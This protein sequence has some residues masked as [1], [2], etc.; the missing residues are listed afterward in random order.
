MCERSTSAGE[1]P[2]RS[3]TCIAPRRAAAGASRLT[4]PAFVLAALL[5]APAMARASVILAA[6]LP[7]LPPP[8]ANGMSRGEPSSLTVAVANTGT[9]IV[10]GV[11]IRLPLANYGLF[12]GAS[13]PDGTWTVTL[14]SVT[15]GPDTFGLVQFRAACSG[16]GIPPSDSARFV[17]QF[18]APASSVDGD[19][20]SSPFQVTG[21][22][23]SGASV[24]DPAPA[25]QTVTFSSPIKALY[26]TGT[27]T[28]NS[29]TRAT[30]TWTVVNNNGNARVNNVTAIPVVSPGSGWSTTGCSTLA[31]LNSGTSGNITCV[32]N[33][34]VPGT[35][36]F[37]ASARDD[38]GTSTAAGATAGTFTYGTVP[39]VTWSKA[40]VVKGLAT[41]ALT[42]NVAAPSSTNVTR[43]DVYNDSAAGWT[44]PGGTAGGSAT[45]GLTYSAPPT[46]TAADVVFT[47]TLTAGLSTDLVVTYS[48]VPAPQS[49]TSYPF[50]VKVT[51]T[52]GPT[53]VSQAVWLVVPIPDVTGL[54]I[55]A[56]QSGQQ[57]SW[58]NT[59]GNGATH[60][61]VVV[62]R[63]P[64]GTAPAMPVPLRQYSVG[65]D[66]VVFITSGG[67]TVSTYL[68][69][70]P[71]SF[72]YRVCN[73]DAY[74]VYSA[75]SSGFW[76]G[77]GWIDAEIAPTGGWVHA[78]ASS[79]LLRNGFLPGNR[80]GVA[81]NG[82]AVN[83][84]DLATGARSFAPHALPAL[85]AGYTPATLLTGTVD[86]GRS[87]L[88]AADQS[89]N[90]TAI[91]LA[92]GGQYWQV[93]K[94]GASFTA[95]AA[96][97][98]RSSA[99]AAF[100]AAYSVDILLIGSSNGS[101]TV[102][103]IDTT[104]G[105]TLWTV[106]A[107]APVRALITYDPLTDIFFV[108][109]DGAGV[110]AFSMAASSPTV[111]APPVPGWIDPASTAHYL[112]TCVRTAGSTGIACLDTGGVLRV[113]NKSTG[114]L[115]AA[116]FTTAV[117]SPTGLVRV[118][119]TS[120]PT[121]FL[122][123]SA[124]SVQVLTA[125]G[126]PY[127]IASVGTWTPGL[128][129]STPVLDG[130]APFFVVGGND[131]R[132][133]RVSLTNVATT[134]QSAQVGTQVPGGVVKLGQPVVDTTNNRYLFST[135]DGHAWAI[136]TN[137]F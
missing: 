82:P 5:I 128:T 113:M 80:L 91:D 27:V 12:T 17:I 39:V 45:N 68:D 99:S 62:F 7:P 107:G 106:T 14:T 8:F 42:L 132:L 16:P 56:D 110:K 48:A 9:Q 44:L 64:A 136:P 105:A 19:A 63:E 76:N 86:T 60:D 61:G 66:R 87:V 84:L 54:T 94:A 121:G 102:Y 23:S 49:G 135:D 100:Q 115:Q 43:I 55:R 59:S 131:R 96:G 74:Y 58:T 6:T 89:G 117:T 34:T 29:A 20:F 37:T 32:Y 13:G 1:H 97:I 103:A 98:T 109:T 78:I 35:Y 92:T 4:V 119:G 36:T 116:P 53:T 72:N 127:T 11:D 73:H 70:T 15:V 41:N 28:R 77:A 122:V 50:R 108:P 30:I 111:A 22:T 69:P 67:S 118:S 79:A 101:G 52:G 65:Q 90:V 126:S 129:L 25:S 40:M 134:T 51:Y 125:T 10:R 93:N 95:G 85:P 88:F 57:L 112:L 46:S 130:T 137:S 24:C 114:A 123:S 47:G 33:F 18:D 31:R 104:N 81:D 83:A 3:R 26:M 71:G 133:H 75:C 38:L 21:S 124:S 2:A 120:A